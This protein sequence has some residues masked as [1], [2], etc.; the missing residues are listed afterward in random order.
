MKGTILILLIDVTHAAALGKLQTIYKTLY[1]AGALS[2]I[3]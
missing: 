2:E 1:T 3:T